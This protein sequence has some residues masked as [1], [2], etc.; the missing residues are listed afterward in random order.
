MRFQQRSRKEWANIVSEEPHFSCL[1]AIVLYNENF[2][3]SFDLY[4]PF[5]PLATGHYN[6]VL[7]PIQVPADMKACIF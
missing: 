4:F 1:F 7:T 6:G 3:A 2:S 5:T